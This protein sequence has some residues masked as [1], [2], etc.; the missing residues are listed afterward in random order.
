MVFDLVIADGDVVTGAGRFRGDVGV[1]DGRIAALGVGL[2]GRERVEARGR[3][4]VP[5]AVDGHVHMRTE[6]P[7]FCY[8][9]T[10]ATGSV[11]AAFGGTTTIIDQVQVEPGQPL[12]RDLDMRMALAEGAS[13]VDFAFHMNI[14]AHNPDVLAEIPDIVA[15]GIPSFK[16]FMAIPGWN[17]PDE[18]LQRGM[19]EVG[20]HGG[21]NIVHAETLGVITELRRR[22]AAAG[23]RD[24]RRFPSAYP[25]GAEAAAVALSLAMAETA[26]SRILLFHQTCAEGVAAIRAAKDRGVAAHGEAGLAWLTHDDSVYAGDQV[27]ALPFLLTPPVRGPAH[28]AA[29]WQGLA[30]GDLDIVSTDHAAVRMVPEEAARAIADGFGVDVVAGPERPDTPRD[31]AGNRLMPVLP[32]GN[33]ETRFP[34]IHS[35]GVATG[36]LSPERWVEV[37]CS[38]PADLFDLPR[39]GR[40][41]PGCDADIVVFDPDRTVT[42]ATDRLHSNTDY[43]V[44]NGWKCRGGVDMVFSRGRKI[45]DGDDWLGAADHGRYLHRTAS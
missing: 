1:A 31:A 26:G 18:I 38:A 41:L 32:P 44:W 35:E 36:R 37:C 40:L 22:K 16:W 10:F 25:A 34:L 42:Y 11:A 21:L 24:M 30:R 29:L 23:D 28:R 17:V 7:S 8:D 6:R 20:A 15:R 33:V 2:Q 5:G 19:I 43:S 12:V 45:V 13:A 14:R 39:K 4:V 27:A 9:D 3:L